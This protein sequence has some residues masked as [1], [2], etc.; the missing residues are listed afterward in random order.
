VMRGKGIALAFLFAGAVACGCAT[1]GATAATDL[2]GVQCEPL[3]VPEGRIHVLVVTNHEC[4]IANSYA[5][6]LRALAEAWRPLPVDLFLVH[7]DPDITVAAARAHAAAYELP[8]HV[9]LDPRQQIAAAVGATRTPEAVVL[10]RS[11]VLYRGRI[12]DQWRALGERLP[13]PTVDDLRAAVA[14]ALKGEP[15]ARPFMPATGCLLPALPR[16]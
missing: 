2:D 11:G 13:A 9:L 14:A 6:T 5:P 3:Q 7:V 12:D 15:V 1:S 4:P 16:D 10:N 8:G